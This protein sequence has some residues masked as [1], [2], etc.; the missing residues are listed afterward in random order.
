MKINYLNFSFVLLL[1]LTSCSGSHK[2]RAVSLSSPMFDLSEDATVSEDAVYSEIAKSTD[3]VIKAETTINSGD[4]IYSEEKVITED[5]RS[6]D[7]PVM[8]QQRKQ[9]KPGVITVG[10]W[11]DLESWSFWNKVIE[12]DDFKSMPGYWTFFNNNRISVTVVGQ[13][14]GPVADVSVKLK[15]NGKTIFSSRT[16][17][18]GK[19][20]L[21]VD[22]FQ[23]ND[24]VDFSTLTIDINNGAAII[25]KVKSYQEGI[26]EIIITSEPAEKKIEIAFV[27]DATGSMGDELEYL[28]TELVDVVSKAEG[29]NPDCSFFTS[30]VFYR[31]EGD[32]YVTKVSNFTNDIDITMNFIRKQSANGGGDFPEA[33]HTAL[34]KAVNELEWSSKARARLL[35]LLLDAPPHYDKNV[36]SSI[37]KTLTAGIEKGIKIIPIT[38]SGIDKETEFLMRF[39]SISTNGTYVFITNHSGIGNA[40]LEPSIGEY[41]VEFLNNLLVRLIN[42]YAQ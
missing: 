7:S 30:A 34:D 26:N 16:D 24:N 29:T 32:D 28:K 15:R 19:S 1:I 38:A 13:D 42:E 11:N 3:D 39:L 9:N 2:E 41:Q 31:D 17:N 33:V 37:Q 20:E 14:S 10:E 6:S 40:H 21:W 35:F 25:S 22:L 23:R 36:I 5:D 8:M 18:K 27:V 4:E 12:R